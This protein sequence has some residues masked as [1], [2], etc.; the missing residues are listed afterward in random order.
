[1]GYKVKP[2][3]Y[4][5]RFAEGHEFHGAE[6]RLRGMSL[7]EYMEAT[8]Q[9][10]GEGDTGAGAAINRFLE[11]LISWNLETEDGQPIPTTKDSV[12]LVDHDLVVALN[13]AWIQQLIGVHDADPLPETSPSGE[14]SQVA[15]I[16]ME[17]LSPSLAS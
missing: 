9:D 15:S 6:A 1:M 5:I 8:G 3:T 14:P 7:G 11:H 16:P 4:L 2:K 13:N 10:G 12:T 17:A